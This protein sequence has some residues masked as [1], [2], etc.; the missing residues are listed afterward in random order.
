ML[1]IIHVSFKN[2][3]LNLT[4]CL[5]KFKVWVSVS[6]FLPSNIKLSYAVFI[7][8]H[9]IL[10]EFT[11]QISLSLIQS[12]CALFPFIVLYISSK[13]LQISIRHRS[14]VGGYSS[15]SFSPTISLTYLIGACAESYWKKFSLYVSVCVCFSVCVCVCIL[16][17]LPR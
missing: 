3:V 2:M 1:L 8:C 16:D 17:I 12:I 5:F 10:I 14:C 4:F 6:Y 9:Y 13:N 7:S 15:V 11:L